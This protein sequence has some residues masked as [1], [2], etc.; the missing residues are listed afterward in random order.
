MSYGIYFDSRT[1]PEALRQA[2][3]TAYEIPEELVYVGPHEELKDGPD[4]APV[5]IIIPA[6]GDF[7]QELS[8]GERL[9]ELTGAT[10][11]DLARTLA[12]T[13]GSRAL[14]DDGGPAPDYWFLV[15]RDGTYGR[16]MTDPDNESL[17]I[18]Y[19]LEPIPGEP[20][21]AVVPPSDWAKT[22]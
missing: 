1:P 3:Q 5:A 18:L 16:V 12:R 11:L 7:G 22:W 14:V 4:P 6:G 2:L 10:E 8:G 21:L 17:T 20:D 13:A 9:A 15:T 19:A